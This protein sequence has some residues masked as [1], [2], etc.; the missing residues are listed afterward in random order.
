M[1]VLRIVIYE[2]APRTKILKE[3]QTGYKAV[4]IPE[5]LSPAQQKKRVDAEIR[6][7]EQ[8]NPDAVRFATALTPN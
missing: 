6:I 3:I 2:F 4:Y 7:V 8:E 1:P 5:N